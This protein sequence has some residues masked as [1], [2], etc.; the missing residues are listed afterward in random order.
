MARSQIIIVNALAK[1]ST[2]VS[3]NVSPTSGLIPFAVSISGR[4][5]DSAGTPLNGKTINLYSNATLIGTTITAVMGPGSPGGDYAFS[6]NITVIGQYQ[7]QTEFLGDADY[8]GCTI[9]NGTHGLLEEAKP[10]LVV[11]LLAGGLL[12]AG[13]VWLLKG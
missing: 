7:F 1:I 5:I 8:E 4:L 2:S 13:A 12:F 3:I 9:H 6:V 10:S 11:P